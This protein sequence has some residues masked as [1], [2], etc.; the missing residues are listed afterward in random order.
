MLE[1]AFPLQLE[2]HLLNCW[3]LPADAAKSVPQG[4]GLAPQGI[5]DE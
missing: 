2:D 4:M 3:A 5:L 1:I